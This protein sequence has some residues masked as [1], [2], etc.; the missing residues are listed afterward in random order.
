M[1]ALL[2]RTFRAPRVA[3]G[4]L[5]YETLAFRSR[6]VLPTP[7]ECPAAC[8][9]PKARLWPLDAPVPIQDTWRNALAHAGCGGWRS[10]NQALW[11][12]DRPPSIRGFTWDT[13][14][15]LP[16]SDPPP[17]RWSQSAEIVGIEKFRRPTR[18]SSRFFALNDPLYGANRATFD[19]SRSLGRLKSVC[20][21]TLT[22]MIPIW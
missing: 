7:D 6:P 21:I 12:P 1:P 11:I 14:M 5:G 3:N 22:T 18:R 4:Y 2:W 9:E 10:R 17:P 19:I 16:Q 20:F 13:L 15:D 8:S